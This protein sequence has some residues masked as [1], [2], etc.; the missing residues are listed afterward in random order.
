MIRSSIWNM[1]G[2]RSSNWNNFDFNNF[3]LIMIKG[4]SLIYAILMNL[5]VL[6]T[7]LY[8]NREQMVFQVLL[9]TLFY[10]LITSTVP[11]GNS[12]TR[13]LIE[14]MLVLLFIKN[15]SKLKN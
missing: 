14:P 3:F 12:R 10:I 13:V 9:I 4:F 1:F 15:L 5:S 11:F 7:L 2:I 8:K 6:K